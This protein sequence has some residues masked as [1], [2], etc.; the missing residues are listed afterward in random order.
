MNQTIRFLTPAEMAAE[1]RMSD[2]TWHR[3]WRY[4]PRVLEKLIWLSAR[5][6]GMRAS[7]WRAILAQGVRRKERRP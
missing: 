3:N 2:A 4:D 5:R 7:D 6:L 1:G